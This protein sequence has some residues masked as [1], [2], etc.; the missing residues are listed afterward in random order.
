MAKC[1]FWGEF[2]KILEQDIKKPFKEKYYLFRQFVE[3]VYGKDIII[4]DNSK[5]IITLKRI[6]SFIPSEEIF[7]ILIVKD[8]RNWTTSAQR[9]HGGNAVKRYIRWYIENKKF[10]SLF[11]A[12]KNGI[13]MGYEEFALNPE[14]AIKIVCGKIGVDFDERMLYPKNSHRHSVFS[15][16]MRYVSY[17]KE[18]ISYDYRWFTNNSICF[19]NLLLPFVMKLNKKLVYS[20]GLHKKFEQ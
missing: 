5:G 3:N 15:N 9:K 4:V 19:A 2:L 13:I 17:K 11:K 6:L 10:Y 7:P 16:R 18:N 12:I 1:E 8:V 14:D 20:N